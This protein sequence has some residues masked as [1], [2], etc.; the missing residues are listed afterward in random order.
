MHKSNFN[1][2][3][4]NRFFFFLLTSGSFSL[5]KTIFHPYLYTIHPLLVKLKVLCPPHGWHLHDCLSE[6]G[7]YRKFRNP[8]GIARRVPGVWVIPLLTYFIYCPFLTEYSELEV[9][10]GGPTHFRVHERE[11]V[12]CYSL[13]LVILRIR[14]DICITCPHFC[15]EL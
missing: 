9:L 15:C 11:S 10:L 7:F 3:R 4:K 13:N 1:M 14:G 5:S 12:V 8:G 2:Q 6:V